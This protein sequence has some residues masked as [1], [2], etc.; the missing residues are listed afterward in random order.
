MIH[1]QGNSL[2]RKEPH[3]LSILACN[4][5]KISLICILYVVTVLQIKSFKIQLQ[6][7]LFYNNTI[8]NAMITMVNQES[9][10]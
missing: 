7:I 3:R 8:H 9:S 10:V 1:T 4:N 2:Q 5:N 6:F